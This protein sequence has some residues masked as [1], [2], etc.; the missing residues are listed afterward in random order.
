MAQNPL[1]ASPPH[2][3]CLPLSVVKLESKKKFN[4]RNEKM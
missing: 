2:A 4:Q 1:W 3:L